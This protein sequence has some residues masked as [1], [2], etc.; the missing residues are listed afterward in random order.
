[1]T[2]P[3]PSPALS[4]I[5]GFANALRRRWIRLAAP[6]IARLEQQLAEEQALNNRLKGGAS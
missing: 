5:A 2:A 3:V 6:H 4:P 1:V